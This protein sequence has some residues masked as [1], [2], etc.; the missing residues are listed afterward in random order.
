[1]LL[2]IGARAATPE[3]TCLPGWLSFAAVPIN[4]S[5]TQLLVLKNS[6][7][8]S[9]TISGI[10]A[11]P[12][13]FN[14]SGMTLPFVLAAGQS[15]GIHVTFSPT[16]SK[17]VR[18]NVQLTSNATNS[19]MQISVQG[20]GVVK[21][22]LQ[23]QPGSVA[24]GQVQVG[25]SQSQS[26]VV[27]SIA[28]NKVTVKGF[29]V[30]GAGFSVSGPAT[31]LVLSPGQTFTVTAKFSPQAAGLVSGNIRILSTA[32]SGL[33]IPLTATGVT[34]TTTGQLA[35]SPSALSLGS[36]R[37]GSSG[38]ASG[39]LSA[40]GASVTVTADNINNSAFT[41]S[42]LTLPVTIAAG[43]SVPFTVKFT[44]TA[45][46]SASATL[47]FT[48]NAQT[49]TTSE[50]LSGT[51][52]TAPGQLAVSPTSLSLGSVVVG[53]SGTASGSLSASGAS[54]TVTA[55]SVN[56]SAFTVTGLSL[57]VTLAA[58]KSVPFTVKF[59]PTAAGSASATLAFT[60]NAQTATTSESLTGTGTAA[61]GQLAVTPTSLGL[62]SIVVG[63]SGTASGSLSASGAS[64]TVTADKINNSAFTVSGLTLPVTIPAGQSVPFTVKFT[65][66]AAGSAS[67]TLAFT[68]NAQTATTN[69]SLTGTGTAA[70]G[71]L[72]VSPS[73]L[74]FGNVDVGTTGM[75]TTTL[76]ASGASV[77]ISS[78][79]M[80][81][82]LF[83]LSGASF[84]MTL[85]AGQSQQMNVVFSPKAS[86]TDS[87][88]L[89]L[90]SNASN[91]KVSESLSGV[92]VTPQYSVSLTWNA[93]TSSVVGYNVY[94]GTSPGAYSKINATVDANTAYTDSTVTA[95]TTYYYA[96]TAVNP[97][98]EESGYSTPVQVTIP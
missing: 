24:L 53:S 76:A 54:V 93:S 14:V 21:G 68:S 64:V 75:L 58:G 95:G 41:L 66:T 46:G 28:S 86:G 51:G 2:P 97:S 5:E 29:Q 1:M 78:A 33:N 96:A 60:S 74:S 12:S 35:V 34:T 52:T 36:V 84:P 77:T 65:P 59:T 89:T 56:N 82:S 57:P 32:S 11:S 71:Q 98:G 31:P 44:P 38:T 19:A 3:L 83:T 92:G 6:G 90:N 70:P 55:D 39:S 16:A 47:A 13:N 62:G 10:A 22:Q 7:K 25:R 88:T 49:A 30:S 81:N 42:G 50:S 37:V 45:A 94:R 15:A 79:A 20:G 91:A 85:G 17:W 23:A 18:G 4:Q 48:S 69:E 40:S 87:G 43:Q 63:S 27:T 80:S 67:A 72:A 26:V 73:T 9:V 8:T 61:P